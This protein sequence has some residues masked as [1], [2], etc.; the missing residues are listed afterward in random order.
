MYG[1]WAILLKLMAMSIHFLCCSVHVREVSKG[2]DQSSFGP[3]VSSDTLH[4][5]KQYSQPLRK[6]LTV[7]LHSTAIAFTCIDTYFLMLRNSTL[8]MIKQMI[9]TGEK[10]LEVFSLTLIKTSTGTRWINKNYSK[11]SLRVDWRKVT[12]ITAAPSSAAVI[13]ICQPFLDKIRHLVPGCNFSCPRVDSP[14][15]LHA[16][17]NL[18]YRALTAES[19]ELI[20]CHGPKGPGP[21]VGGSHQGLTGGH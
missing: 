17:Q 8:R 16:G 21:G 20:T 3:H 2:R 19:P 15:G 14:R 6:C 18:A 10:P 7:S 12:G 1:F 9:P 5:P 4:K 13:G 11:T